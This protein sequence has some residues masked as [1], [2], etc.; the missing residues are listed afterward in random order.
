M[1]N[2]VGDE[3]YYGD[4]D[5]IGWAGHAPLTD[6]AFAVQEFGDMDHSAYPYGINLDIPQDEAPQADALETDQSDAWV[7]KIS[8][9]IKNLEALTNTAL[10]AIAPTAANAVL[11]ESPVSDSWEAYFNT[12][13]YFRRQNERLAAAQAAAFEAQKRD[14]F[15]EE[16]AAKGLHPATTA[17]R[18]ATATTLES[19]CELS[20]L[21]QPYFIVG[22]SG[23]RTDK[24]GPTS[25]PLDILR[26]IDYLHQSKGQIVLFD[27]PA[28]L[29]VID[30]SWQ[31]AA[32]EMS[33]KLRS[34]EQALYPEDTPLPITNASEL[35]N[36]DLTRFK[37][38]FSGTK[39][40]LKAHPEILKKVW[41]IVPP[42][43][44][45]TK[46]LATDQAY[47]CLDTKEQIQALALMDYEILHLAFILFFSG[48]KI[49]HGRSEER[50]AQVIRMIRSTKEYKTLLKD[51]DK[52]GKIS[53][54]TATK[55]ARMQADAYP[56]PYRVIGG[57]TGLTIGTVLENGQIPL[58]YSLTMGEDLWTLVQQG[59]QKAVLEYLT[60]NT[61]NPQ[62]KQQIS[63]WGKWDKIGVH[64]LAALVSSNILWPVEKIDIIKL[65]SSNPQVYKQRLGVKVLE[66]QASIA[67]L[68]TLSI[69][70]EEIMPL[71]YRGAPDLQDTEAYIGWLT[72]GLSDPYLQAMLHLQEYSILQHLYAT[73]QDLAQIAGRS[74]GKE[75]NWT[76]TMV[77][78]DIRFNNKKLTTALEKSKKDLEFDE[79][80]RAQA[81]H[82][83]QEVT[84]GN[85][86]AGKA[87]ACYTLMYWG[88]RGIGDIYPPAS[89][90]VIKFTLVN[91]I[92]PYL[93][94]NSKDEWV[95]SIIRYFHEHPDSTR[96][97]ARNGQ[98]LIEEYVGLREKELGIELADRMEATSDAYY[99]LGLTQ[100]PSFKRIADTHREMAQTTRQLHARYPKGYFDKDPKNTSS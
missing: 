85:K 99:V 36:G 64:E 48:E 84:M 27:A 18:A 28:L 91:I 16:M 96:F 2:R 49:R 45:K 76:Q 21:A 20:T 56:N 62:L 10:K 57:E 63:E 66:I 53:E 95:L 55:G 34:V 50:S 54:P 19:G 52:Q 11:N 74:T 9:Q 65:K 24:T 37:A 42:S 35:V 33:A 68:P 6:D 73:L 100:V 93:E 94:K 13:P 26:Y 67:L 39:A 41:Q 98:D 88:L 59:K 22:L 75:S 79:E 5:I 83:L 29:N 78:I 1:T 82:D 14:I 17:T 89:D 69:L 23:G 92:V 97:L 44:K 46:N 90:D 80:Q 3:Y 31:A 51:L 86:L 25:L 8:L 4:T 70:V 77:E 81:V 40:I 72:E 32:Q 47:E 87:Q 12:I 38:I 60:A 43:A 7:K 58:R 61:A 71:Y 30:T 15:G